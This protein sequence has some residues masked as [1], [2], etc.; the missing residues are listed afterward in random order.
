[1]KTRCIKFRAWDIFDKRMYSWSILNFQYA[2]ENPDE[3]VLMQCT[4]RTDKG[5]NDVYEGDIFKDSCHSYIVYWNDGACGFKVKTIN[6][7]KLIA[8]KYNNLEGVIKNLSVIGNKYENPKM[9]D[10]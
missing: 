1:M 6:G 10:G 3:F 5:G 9:C 8:P 2:L 7:G 4:G